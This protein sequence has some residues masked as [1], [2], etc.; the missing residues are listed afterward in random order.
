MASVPLNPYNLCTIKALYLRDWLTYF[1][2]LDICGN[3]TH[4]CVLSIVSLA[5]S[6]ITFLT[7]RLPERNKNR[8][9]MLT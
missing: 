4:W 8:C 3:E 2:V 9:T 6:S 7:E 1:V 5:S